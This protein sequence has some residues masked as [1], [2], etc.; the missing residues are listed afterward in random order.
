MSVDFALHFLDWSKFKQANALATSTESLLEP[1]VL[2]DAD[3][4]V[5]VADELEALEFVGSCDAAIVASD[6]YD[7]LR[8]HLDAKSREA[9]DELFATLFWGFSIQESGDYPWGKEFA[10]RPTPASKQVRFAPLDAP[11]QGEPIYLRALLSPETIERLAGV[12]HEHHLAALASVLE[13]FSD[14]EDLW[15]EWF[16]SSEELGAYYT[17]W[18]NVVR[19]AQSQ[20][21]GLALCVG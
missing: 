14:D 18:C 19:L 8:E 6:H 16:T 17:Q 13:Q 4:A 9:F 10:Q 1:T 15:E 3:Y 21:S 7:F 20:R 2:E 5:N 11:L 12:V